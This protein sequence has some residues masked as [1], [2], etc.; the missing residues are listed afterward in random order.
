MRVILIL[1]LILLCLYAC[2]YVTKTTETFCDDTW[3]T[4]I[5]NCKTSCG[6]PYAGA[7]DD[8]IICCPNGTTMYAFHQY[9]K[10]MQTGTSC[11]SGDMCANGTCED[12]WGGIV[13][14]TCN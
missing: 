11:W 3:G 7:S 9:C 2:V 6:R 13:K 8:E 14:G 4:G 12:N 5:P 1:L 10:G